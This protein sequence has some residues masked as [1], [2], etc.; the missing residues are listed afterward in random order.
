VV[1][2]FNQVGWLA[3][4]IA[5]VIPDNDRIVLGPRVYGGMTMPPEVIFQVVKDRSLVGV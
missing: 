5:S 1:P 2:E 3:R 4:E